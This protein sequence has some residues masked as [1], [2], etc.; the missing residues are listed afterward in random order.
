MISK[1]DVYITMRLSKTPPVQ[2][3]CCAEVR[4]R[5]C[6]IGCTS[7]G[8]GDGGDDL[9]RRYKQRCRRR[10]YVNRDSISLRKST[11]DSIASIL[12]FRIQKSTGCLT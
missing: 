2:P 3:T 6:R 1:T 4:D 5:R 12:P 11:L 8:A 10:S 9:H 7:C